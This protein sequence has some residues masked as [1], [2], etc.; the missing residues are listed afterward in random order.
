MDLS[1]AETAYLFGGPK[2]AVRGALASLH[3]RGA[4]KPGPTGTLERRDVAAPQD[5]EPL[6]RALYQGMVDTISMLDLMARQRVSATL[7][8][9]RLG[10]VAKGLLRPRWF[11]AVVPPALVSL[12][13]YLLVRLEVVS[14]AVGA[15]LT[16][17]L[18][19][20][21]TGLT[22]RLTVRGFRTRQALRRWHADLAPGSLEP[23]LSASGVP[24]IR[25]RTEMDPEDVGLAVAVF[26]RDALM[27]LLPR[28]TAATGLLHGGRRGKVAFSPGTDSYI[29][30]AGGY[31]QP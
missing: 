25:D 27:E 29:H 12:P 20:I 3:V 31:A 21:A 9:L 28:F 7:T 30:G 23:R 19:A 24:I 4:V 14:L 10:L 18:A 5:L 8:D 17:V 22:T 2:A 16:L 11:R 26:G 15:A 6:E 13:P 1:V